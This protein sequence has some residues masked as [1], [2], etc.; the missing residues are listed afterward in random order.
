MYT[1]AAKKH[2][3]AIY[4]STKNSAIMTAKELPNDSNILMNIYTDYADSAFVQFFQSFQ[5]SFSSQ[6]KSYFFNTLD[7]AVNI[8]NHL[9]KT[10]LAAILHKD[11]ELKKIEV[12]TCGQGAT[13]PA[14]L[15]S[16]LSRSGSKKLP[17][18]K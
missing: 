13:R 5:V 10:Q 2:D 11:I 1:M 3:F 12:W 18:Y 7:H 16:N 8:Q 4:S 9:I 6:S 17:Y 15:K 14:H